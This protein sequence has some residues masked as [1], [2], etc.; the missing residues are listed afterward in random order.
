M[1]KLIW[2]ILILCSS[3]NLF[4]KVENLKTDTD[5]KEQYSQ[6][7]SRKG[8]TVAFKVPRITFKDTTIYRV[9][10]QGT[11]LRTVFDTDGHVSEIECM[12][13]M[14]D[15]LIQMNRALLQNTS[16]KKVEKEFEGGINWTFISLGCM[17]I[18]GV[19]LFKKL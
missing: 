5:L 9:N 7:I 15:E 16:D 18:L 3:C 17:A 4:R 1:K 10:R 6:K 14:I 13:S 12:S 2:L 19:I 11:T 8:D